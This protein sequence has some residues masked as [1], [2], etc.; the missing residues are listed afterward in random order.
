M[1]AGQGHSEEDT[2]TVVRAGIAAWNE[3]D[4]GRFEA[5][6]HP[7]VEVRA[8]EGWPESGEFKGWAAVRRQFERLKEPWIEERVEVLELTCR[9]ERALLHGRWIGRGTSGLDFDMDTWQSITVRGGRIARTEFYL[10]E[11]AARQA[12]GR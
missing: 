8:P 6:N 1:D 11:A 7:D 5:V 2:E 12:F 4:W 3:N 9:G 10:D